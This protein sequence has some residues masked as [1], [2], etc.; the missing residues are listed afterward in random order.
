MSAVKEGKIRFVEGA[1][2]SVPGPRLVQGAQKVAQFLYP[3]LFP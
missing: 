1:L 2:F 3:N